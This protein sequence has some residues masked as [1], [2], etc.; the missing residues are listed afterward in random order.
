MLTTQLEH[1]FP[2][3]PTY[4]FDLDTLLA[5]KAPSAPA[6]LVPFWQ[7]TYRAA[8]ELPLHL[9]RRKADI[10]APPNVDVFEIE[11]DSWEGVRI[12]G[13]LTVPRGVDVARGI[14]AGHGYGGRSG[15][16]YGSHSL[17]AA[18]I[19]PCMRGQGRSVHS[20]IPEISSEHVLHGIASVEGYVLRGCVVDIWRAASALIE[21]VPNASRKLDYAG[22]SFGGGLGAMALAWDKRFSRGFLSVPTFGNHPVRVALPC[23]GSG[24]AVRQYAADHPAVLDVL[25]YYDAATIA[26]HVAQPVFCACALFDP[27]VPPPG[28][29]SVYNALGANK[30]LFVLPTGHFDTPATAKAESE[31]SGRVENWFE[32][33][34]P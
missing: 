13:W 32:L 28:Q 15:P 25:R 17:C 22:G 29:F 7:E 4:G 31:L 10:D 26:A 33:G 5:I 21:L 18:A 12:G 6:D 9:A 19:Y 34:A 2:F 24:E 23:T 27:A 30:R 3:D 16:D 1:P 14:V 11:Y 20:L 8:L